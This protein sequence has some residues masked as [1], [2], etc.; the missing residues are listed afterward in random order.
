VSTPKIARNQEH[1]QLIRRAALPVEQQ[2]LLEAAL[3]GT[4][5]CRLAEVFACRRRRSDRLHRARKALRDRMAGAA[6]KA[7]LE[8]SRRWTPGSPA[9]PAA[10]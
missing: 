6:P 9:G 5:G 10:K 3:L 7:A 2:T 4:W 8:T 1:R